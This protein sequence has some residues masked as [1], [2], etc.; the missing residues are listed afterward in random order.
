MRNPSEEY[1]L[2]TGYW[3][4][5]S[6][7]GDVI[8]CAQRSDWRKFRAAQQSVRDSYQ[9]NSFSAFVDN[10][11]ERRRRHGLSGHVQL[12]LDLQQQSQQQNW[13]EFQNYHLTHHERLEKKRDGL[14]KKLNDCQ[15]KAGVTD[16]K[17]SER[18]AQNERA[19]QGRLEFAERTLRWHEVILWWIERQRVRMDPRS[20]TPNKDTDDQNTT[21]L[22]AVLR[23]STRQRQSRQP[24][25]STVRGMVRVSKPTPKSRKMRTQTFKAL[26]SKPVIVD[27]DITTPNCIQHMPKHQ[28]TK[29]SCAKEKPLGPLGQLCPQRVS[30][31]NRFGGT[32][33]KSRP[34]IRCHGTKLTP[35]QPRLTS[36]AFK[37]QSG[38]LSRPPVRWHAQ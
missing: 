37:T 19:I 32:S 12:L 22:K 9:H 13:I 2:I 1:R 14:K 8:L 23:V 20:L 17:G 6:S 15:K 38:R 29:P 25:T 34:G 5:F 31:S 33:M 16:V 26:K 7:T 18:I 27:T 4:S 30:K 35:P 28:E 11:C 36:G 24:G 21:L 3:K 10:V